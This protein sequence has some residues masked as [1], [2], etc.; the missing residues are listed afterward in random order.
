MLTLSSRRIMA[1]P[2][3]KTDIVTIQVGSSRK[4]FTL[5]RSIL[6]SQSAYFADALVTSKGHLRKGLYFP[7]ADVQAFEL[8][9]SIMHDN[10]MPTTTSITTLIHLD[11]LG[12]VFYISKVSHMAYV[13]L[14]RY[15]HAKRVAPHPKY[16]NARGIANEC[17]ITSEHLQLADRILSDQSKVRS[18]LR[19]E[20]RDWY[21]TRM[22]PRS[23][24]SEPAYMT[25]AEMEHGSR[26]A[27]GRRKKRKSLWGRFL[28]SLFG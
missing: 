24:H 15:L 28:D 12:E 6:I 19:T 7:N 22:V 5:S 13:E 25:A 8:F 10:H 20:F 26:Y 14:L 18:L 17:P 21:R 9:V 11:G 23:R 4:S 16:P 2:L 27:M 3:N 1:L